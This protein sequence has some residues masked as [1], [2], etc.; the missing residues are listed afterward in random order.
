MD[1][2][3][4]TDRYDR[5]LKKN[6]VYK[7]TVKREALK[8]KLAPYIRKARA[9][10]RKEFEE[11]IDELR[12]RANQ[13]YRKIPHLTRRA[14]QER[15]CRKAMEARLENFKDEVRKA[16]VEV[17][18]ARAAAAAARKEAKE[19]AAEHARKWNNMVQKTKEGNSQ[20]NNYKGQ[21]ASKL[22]QAMP[23]RFIRAGERSVEQAHRLW[24]M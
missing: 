4:G 11:E 12:R 7:E 3:R 20:N 18:A 2:K 21:K 6:R 17:K 14:E 16:R 19:Q 9:E 13:Y 24:K 10:A 23:T 1:A 8:R 5:K 15:A 22:W